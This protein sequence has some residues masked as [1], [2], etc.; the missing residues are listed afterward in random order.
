MRY[1]PGTSTSAAADLHRSIEAGQ[2]AVDTCPPGSVF[3]AA[4]LANL[5]VALRV[6]DHAD[7]RDKRSLSREAA[8]HPAGALEVRV[9]AAA[10]WGTWAAE[11]GDWVEGAVGMGAAVSLLTRVAPRGLPRSDQE[12]ELA[13]LDGLGSTRRVCAQHRR[14]R[15]GRSPARTGTGVLL[16]QTLISSDE[17]ATN[18]VRGSS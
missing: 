16:A 6:R 13:R 9:R 18:T 5:A 1:V 14:G 2:Q 17:P 10:R 15:G 8:R 4:C 3:R 12:F 7:D 11:R